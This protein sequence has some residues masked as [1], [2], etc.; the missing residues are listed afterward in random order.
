MSHFAQPSGEIGMWYQVPLCKTKPSAQG[1][2]Y[3]LHVQDASSPQFGD[4]CESSCTHSGDGDCDDGGPGASY[5][6]CALGSDCEDCGSRRTQLPG[7]SCPAAA[8]TTSSP[9]SIQMEPLDG[10]VLGRRYA[11]AFLLESNMAALMTVVVSDSRGTVL[12]PELTLQLGPTNAFPWTASARR[13]LSAESDGAAADGKEG[14]HPPGRRPLKGGSGGY[15]ATMSGGRSR[16]YGAGRWGRS[17]GGQSTR[18]ARVPPTFVS[19][20]GG[21]SSAYAAQRGSYYYGASAVPRG[22]RFVVVPPSYYHCFACTYTSVR[23]SLIS[24]HGRRCDGSRYDCGQTSSFTADSSLDRYELSE[25]LF[26]APK[27]RSRW[28]LTLEVTKLDLYPLSTAGAVDAAGSARGDSGV[29][30]ALGR[31]LDARSVLDASPPSKTA[32]LSFSTDDGAGYLLLVDRMWV[33]MSLGT[34][35]FFFAAALPYLWIFTML[36]LQGVL[37]CFATLWS[38]NCMRCCCFRRRLGPTVKSQ[39]SL[40]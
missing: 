28:P 39:S 7:F 18:T 13:H 21:G 23:L 19:R 8:P 26:D 2:S 30:M 40:L 15:G 10:F 3:V 27:D 36:A 22:A 4:T 16:T 9:A 31:R 12:L 35:F 5:G 29:S 1:P 24:S 6:L 34:V 37:D 25:A 14:L 17:A 38:R 33:V 20:G 32:L 11:P